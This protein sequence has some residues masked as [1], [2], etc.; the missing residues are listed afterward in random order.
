MAVD[1]LSETVWTTD[2]DIKWTGDRYFAK[3][4]FVL[5][6]RFRCFGLIDLEVVLL[7]AIAVYSPGMWNFSFCAY[8]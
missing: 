8:L 4:V 1:P 2:M 6:R 3:H 5:A 7:K